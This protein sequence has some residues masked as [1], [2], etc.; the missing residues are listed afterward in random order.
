MVADMARDD[1]WDG[2]GWGDDNDYFDPPPSRD[3]NEILF[4]NDRVVDMEAQDLFREAFFNDNQGA[5][6][7]LIDYMW[8]QYGIDFEDAFTW[9]DFREW[10]G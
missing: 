6:F 3:V 10:Y 1:D 5:Y 8:E 9:E 4:G 2:G 7:D